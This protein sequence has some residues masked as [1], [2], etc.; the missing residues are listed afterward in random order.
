M[1][2]RDDKKARRIVGAFGDDEIQDEIAR[3]LRAARLEGRIEAQ[4]ECWEAVALAM[5]LGALGSA[6]DFRRKAAALRDGVSK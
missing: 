6:N 2:D 1:T 4:A 3:S 5:D